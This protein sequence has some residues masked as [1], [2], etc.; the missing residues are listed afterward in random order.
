MIR[1]TFA[2]RRRP[3]LSLEAF[4]EYWKTTHA[5]LVAAHAGALGIRRYV[6]VHTLEDPANAAMAKR[7]GHMEEPFDGVAELWFDSLGALAA[8][9]STDAG[10]EAA[11]TLVEDEDRFIDLAASPLWLAV[12]HPQVNPTPETVVAHPSSSIVKLHYPLRCPD[13]WDEAQAQQY[14]YTQH[15][16]LIRRH[17]Q[18]MGI[19]RYVQVH[20]TPSGVEEAM[21]RVRGT[22]ADPYMGHAELWFDRRDTVPTPERHAGSEAAVTDESH[23]IDFARSAIFFAKEHVIF[24]LR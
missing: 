9:G 1:L 4:Q 20:R 2:L 14:W 5:P 3:E 17:A 18:A 19:Q 8:A 16:P 22:E 12:E 7:R 15:G 13:N 6:Q 21:R 23:F 11:G 24:D 10:S